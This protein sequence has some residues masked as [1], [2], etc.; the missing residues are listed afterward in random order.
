MANRAYIRFT[1]VTIPQGATIRSAWP[2][3]T[4]F[5]SQ[6]ASLLD[7]KCYFVDADDPDAPANK[8]ELD[9]F[10]LTAAIDWEDPPQWVDGLQYNAPELKT[11]LQ[12]VIDRTGWESGNALIL[13]IEDD[14]SPSNV[15]RKFSSVNYLAA[16]ER[17][18][19]NVTWYSTVENFFDNSRWE[20]AQ[21]DGE[22][23]IE[24]SWSGTQWN[25]N[26]Y[27]GAGGGKLKSKG[28]W[29]SGYKPGGMTVYHDHVGPVILKLYA[30]DGILYYDSAYTSG[31]EFE[32]NWTGR[33]GD[34][35]YLVLEVAD[36]DNDVFHVTNIDF[37][38]VPATGQTS[39]STTSTIS[40]TSSTSSTASTISTIST[41]SSTSST[42]STLSTTSS[43]SSTSSTASST[44][45]SSSTSSTVSTH[46]T[47]S[48]TSSTASTV[49]TASTISTT[50]TSTSSSTSSTI[51]T[52]ST[53]SSTSSTTSSSST[54][55]TAP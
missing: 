33:T 55:T 5:D 8:T 23:A 17:T 38:S 50:T 37:N 20:V 12:T 1:N 27:A 7:A 51:S 42:A 2:R 46:T 13:V 10:S 41:T 32:P 25:F 31:T 36:G 29:M 28:T 9:A 14:S 45:T 30:T 34:I 49:S 35:E 4:A 52:T 6:T 53:T 21:L 48:T 3:F 11:I 26:I 22:T 54:T 43:S 40:T 39:T 19:F 16:S 15:H 47:L 24:T 44:S 18:S